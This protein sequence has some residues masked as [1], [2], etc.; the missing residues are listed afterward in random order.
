MNEGI[1]RINI[2]KIIYL[3][4]E[5]YERSG[6]ITLVFISILFTSYQKI[7]DNHAF[8]TLDFMIFTLISWVVGWQYDKARYFEKKA[9]A[10]E[11]S[12]KLL[13]DSLPEPVYITRNHQFL[14]VNNAAASLFRIGQ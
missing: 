1:C 3:K 12:Y 6:Q 9:R 14:Y 11:E 5:K 7:E 8:F 2:Y 13:I 4:R 10:S